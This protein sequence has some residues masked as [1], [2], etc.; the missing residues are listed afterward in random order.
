MPSIRRD[1]R[2]GERSDEQGAKE[3]KT[4]SAE[5]E[6]HQQVEKERNSGKDGQFYRAHLKPHQKREGY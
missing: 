4:K 1:A 2:N 6:K 5:S 3:E